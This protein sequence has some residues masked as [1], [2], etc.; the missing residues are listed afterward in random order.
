MAYDPERDVV[1]LW[2]GADEIDFLTDT[3]EWDGVTW[4]EVVTANAPSG[5][6]G[7]GPMFWDP[8]SETIILVVKPASVSAPIQTWSYDGVDWT[9]LS[10]STVPLNGYFGSMAYYPAINRLVLIGFDMAGTTF[11]DHTVLWDGS[12]WTNTSPAAF[13]DVVTQCQVVYDPIADAVLKVYGRTGLLGYSDEVWAYDGSTW[14]NVSPGGTSPAARAM[15]PGAYVPSCGAT[16]IFSGDQLDN[17]TWELSGGAGAWTQ[18]TPAS[19]PTGRITFVGSPIMCLNV[20][21]NDAVMFGG[22]E[23]GGS[24]VLDDTWVAACAAELGTGVFM[25]P[26]R[27]N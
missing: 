6:N 20:G 4:Q 19:V 15:F 8:N 3:W 13:P 5:V 16:V 2:G 17:E 18:E 26:R 10:P 25:P 24:A 23:S 22:Q 1:V 14:T 21:E 27:L 11:G 12:N 7:G 9:H